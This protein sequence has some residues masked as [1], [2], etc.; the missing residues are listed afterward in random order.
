MNSTASAAL[1]SA[2]K[3]AARP[4]APTAAGTPDMSSVGS[5]SSGCGRFGNRTRAIMPISI[6]TNA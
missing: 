4:N 3:T 5:A 1:S 2:E 6:G